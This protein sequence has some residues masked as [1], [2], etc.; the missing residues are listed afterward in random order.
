MWLLGEK[1]GGEIRHVWCWQKACLCLIHWRN[2]SG[3]IQPCENMTLEIL[4]RSEKPEEICWVRAGPAKKSC[5]E[6]AWPCRWG[7][8]HQGPSGAVAGPLLPFSVLACALLTG[9]NVPGLL[10]P[11]W[12]FNHFWVWKSHCSRMKLL[13]GSWVF[14]RSSFHAVFFAFC[15]V[16]KVIKLLNHFPFYLSGPAWGRR[17]C[18]SSCLQSMPAWKVHLQILKRYVDSLGQSWQAPSTRRRAQ[19]CTETW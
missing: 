13:G 12:L 8:S 11:T 4:P 6:T 10:Q 7:S 17:N 14:Y 15:S 2:C 9:T 16:L 5:P 3:A 19:A 18:D 1:A